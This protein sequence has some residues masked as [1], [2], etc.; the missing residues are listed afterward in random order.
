MPHTLTHSS[1]TQPCEG[2]LEFILCLHPQEFYKAGCALNPV[3]CF[4][5]SGLTSDIPEWSYVEAGL[6]FDP[7]IPPTAEELA[8]LLSVSPIGMAPK[9]Q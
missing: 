6:T 5:L 1:L 7:A 2:F 8:Q 4:P 9:V 3:T